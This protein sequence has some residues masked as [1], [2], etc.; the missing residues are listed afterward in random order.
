MKGNQNSHGSIQV[1]VP[2]L[3]LQDPVDC[4]RTSKETVRRQILFRITFGSPWRVC[5]ILFVNTQERGKQTT[6]NTVILAVA[7][8]KKEGDKID[9][10]N[11]NNQTQNSSTYH[12][13]KW[14]KMVTEDGRDMLADGFVTN[15]TQQ[16]MTMWS[17][18]LFITN[19]LLT[20]QPSL[21]YEDASKKRR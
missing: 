14:H 20:V 6:F 12:S 18:I 3:N 8:K 9:C 16:T 17:G 15:R 1:E 13:F 5:S 4:T 11:N 2:S 21:M 19:K 10:R 7:T